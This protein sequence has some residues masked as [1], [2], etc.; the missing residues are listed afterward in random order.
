MEDSLG[1]GGVEEDLAL[2]DVAEEDEAVWVDTALGGGVQHSTSLEN[3][4]VGAEVIAFHECELVLVREVEWTSSVLHQAE[5][6]A[7]HALG[8]RVCAIVAGR[9]KLSTAEAKLN[10]VCAGGKN[11]LV[12][13]NIVSIYL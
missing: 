5:V 2:L 9:K 3:E 12:A 10:V 1:E 6:E 8:G 7:L 13:T 4:L 11:G